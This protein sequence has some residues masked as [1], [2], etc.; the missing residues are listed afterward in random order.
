MAEGSKTTSHISTNSDRASCHIPCFSHARIA[1]FDAMTL[2]SSFAFEI[3]LSS[4]AACSH[5]H[6]FAHALIAALKLMTLGSNLFSR[7]S[8]KRRSD[9]CHWSFAHALI[10]A[11]KL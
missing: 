8:L 5:C 9:R 3:P 6:P 11:L 10:P 2:C 4:D 7:I 1:T